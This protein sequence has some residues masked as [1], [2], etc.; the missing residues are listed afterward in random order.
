MIQAENVT[1]VF[2]SAGQS[3]P[4]Y[5]L[6]NLSCT[7]PGG[8]IYGLVGS[9]GAGKS[10]FLRLLSGVY[11]PDHGTISVDGLPVWE[12]PTAKDKLFYVPDDLYFLPQTSMRKMAHYYKALYRKFDW[13]RYCG[14][15]STFGLDDEVPFLRYTAVRRMP[16][17]T[18]LS[19]CCTR[20]P[21]RFKAVIKEAAE[22]STITLV[23]G[24]SFASFSISLQ[25]SSSVSCFFLFL[26]S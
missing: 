23:T 18:E 9:N 7:I 13:E 8:C 6:N 26:P 3:K 22:G 11:R 14:L 21:R 17:S 20:N 1:K 2:R 19:A 25:Y 12:N 15:T 10:T 4:H 24:K 5:A 16:S